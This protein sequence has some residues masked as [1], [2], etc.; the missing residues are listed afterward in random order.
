MYICIYI[1]IYISTTFYTPPRMAVGKTID[2]ARNFSSYFNYMISVKP[3]LCFSL[4]IPAKPQ[5]ATSVNIPYDKT[6]NVPY[7]HS[8]SQSQLLA[9]WC[10]ALSLSAYD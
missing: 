9:P 6:D 3:S 5:Q 7:I 4:S 8:P 10:M 1:H 2:Q